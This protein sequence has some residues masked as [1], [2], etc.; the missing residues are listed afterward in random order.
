MSTA[1]RA[2]NRALLLILGTIL[3]AGGALV[4]T[5]AV[6][7]PVA[8][9][10]ADAGV[11]LT[12]WFSGAA[13]ASRIAGTQL[14]GAGV[15]AL[16]AVLAAIAVLGFALSHVRGHRSGAMARSVDAANALG[17]I[18]MTEA[19]AADALRSTLAAHNEILATRVTADEVRREPVLHVAV[20][21]RRHTSPRVIADR[22]D[23][24]VA[25]LAA[26]TGEDPATCIF[27]HAGIRARLMPDRRR[28][29]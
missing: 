7:P 29:S 25:N 19:F 5:A 12:R 8:R 22:V 27:V 3:T 2:L 17:P 24:L 1:N 11:A 9:G 10:W 4:V 21:P 14:T 20:T 18:T 16:A 15:A 6:W 23:G 28:V 26:L 13:E